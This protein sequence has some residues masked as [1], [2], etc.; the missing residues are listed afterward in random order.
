MFIQLINVKRVRENPEAKNEHSKATFTD[1]WKT[2]TLTLVLVKAYQGPMGG[3]QKNK[4][5]KLEIQETGWVMKKS[6]PQPNKYFADPEY[7][8]FHEDLDWTQGNL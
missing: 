6:V 3:L 5:S 2:V 4:S 8:L 1:S 7:Y